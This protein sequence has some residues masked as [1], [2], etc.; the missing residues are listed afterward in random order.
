MRRVHQRQLGDYSHAEGNGTTAKGNF[1]HAEGT[2][3]VGSSLSIH[4]VGI[5]E[6]KQKCKSAEEIFFED[7]NVKNGYKYLI[8]IGGFDGTNFEVDGAL[9]PDIKSVQEVIN[10]LASSSVERIPE[11]VINSLT[12]D[13]AGWCARIRRRDVKKCNFAPRLLLYI[14]MYGFQ[15]VI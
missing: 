15:F 5:G 3:N 8:G 2:C 6:S 9:N 7:N 12:A 13:Y 1:S 14:V 11:D 10:E 4:S